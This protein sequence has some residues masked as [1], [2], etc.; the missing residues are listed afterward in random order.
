[1]PI[2]KNGQEKQ[3][4]YDTALSNLRYI[5]KIVRE[6]HGETFELSAASILSPVFPAGSDFSG[7]VRCLRWTRSIAT[8]YSWPERPIQTLL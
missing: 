1:L 4:Q 8:I 6:M 7:Y 3:P 2:F 5:R